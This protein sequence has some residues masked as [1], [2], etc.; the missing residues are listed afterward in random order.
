[1]YLILSLLRRLVLRCLTFNISFWARHLQGIENKV[2]DVLIFSFRFF[3]AYT[4]VGEGCWEWWQRISGI[5]IHFQLRGW[6]NI[7]QKFWVRR[8]L[9]R[10]LIHLN[11]IGLDIFFSGLQDGIK[12]A[13]FLLGEGQN[14]M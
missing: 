5:S 3:A 6:E 9:R 8:T 11:D 13:L 4:C 1:M 10:L 12:Q 14:A 2:A 7:G